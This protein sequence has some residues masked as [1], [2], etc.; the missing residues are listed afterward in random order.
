MEC[1][2]KRCLRRKRSSPKLQKTLL[3][4]AARACRRT[5]FRNFPHGSQVFAI[6]CHVLSRSASSIDC[7][8]FRLLVPIVNSTCKFSTHMRGDVPP[9]AASRSHT[10]AY[11]LDHYI[12][13]LPSCY[14]ED[15]AVIDI[16]LLRR[17]SGD[18]HPAFHIQLLL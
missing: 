15:V 14:T 9:L 6:T 13:L 7:P 3:V 12:L 16:L 11:L 2:L 4:E 10:L 18:S 1:H 17:C 8:D 5:C